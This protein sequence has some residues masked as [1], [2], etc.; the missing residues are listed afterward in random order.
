[1]CWMHGAV[2]PSRHPSAV[3]NV[4]VLSCIV[5]SPIPSRREGTHRD[6]WHRHGQGRP[7]VA[8]SGGIA[9]AQTIRPDCQAH[10]IETCTSTVLV[11]TSKDKKGSRHACFRTLITWNVQPV[12]SHMPRQPL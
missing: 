4:P 11:S 12:L 1:M 8:T 5:A 9:R 3:L 2:F 6:M 7:V 10:L